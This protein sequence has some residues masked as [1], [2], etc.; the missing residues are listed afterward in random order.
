METKNFFKSIT[1]I[2]LSCCFLVAV[3]CAESEDQIVEPS[4]IASKANMKDKGMM[5]DMAKVYVADLMPLNNSGVTGTAT[6]KIHADQSI[7]AKVHAKGLAP[8]VVHPQHIHGF[9]M[10]D[11]DAVCPPASAAGEDGL[12]TLVD[13]LPFYGPVIVPLDNMLVPLAINEFP[14]ANSAGILN[15][16]EKAGLDNFLSAFDAAFGMESLQLTKRVVVLH[17]AYVKGGMIVPAGT[18]GAEYVAT[19]P[20]ACGE[21][22]VRSNGKK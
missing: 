14:V 21:I 13:G 1:P 2:F 9:V 11:K 19:L 5:S 12:L 8:N 17:G 22:M 10:E 7:H 15:Y 20:V 6:F 3:S 4:N 18:E 16:N